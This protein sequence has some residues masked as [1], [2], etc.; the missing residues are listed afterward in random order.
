MLKKTWTKEDLKNALGEWYLDLS[1]PSKITKEMYINA[2]NGFL[3]A[4]PCKV[5]VPEKENI[6][7]YTFSYAL[8]DYVKIH[9]LRVFY[10]FFFSPRI[11]S[12]LTKWPKTIHICMKEN[13]EKVFLFET[14]QGYGT[15][16]SIRELGLW[17]D[18]TTLSVVYYSFVV[19]P[20]VYPS[21]LR[22]VKEIRSTL[23][24]SLVTYLKTKDKVIALSKP[25]VDLHKSVIEFTSQSLSLKTFKI[26]R[27]RQRYLTMP[28]LDNLV[29]WWNTHEIITEVQA[30]EILAKAKEEK[31]EKV[32]SD[33][34]RSVSVADTLF[35]PQSH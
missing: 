24:S 15:R 22:Q 33:F 23:N 16:A 9:K 20:I 35:N 34:N 10:P 5:L 2:I 6:R 14:F 31:M 30:K 7:T 26:V 32:L 12:S 29:K 11:S 1:E 4:N 19:N 3:N 27:D 25:K 13:G 17:C 18:R 28:L 21:F 8:K